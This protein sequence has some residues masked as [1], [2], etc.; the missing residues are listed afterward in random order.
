MHLQKTKRNRSVI[1]TPHGWKKLQDARRESEIWENDGERYTLET[2]SE[3]TGLG[4][5]TIAKVLAREEGVDKQT[6]ERFFSAFNLELDKD[7]YCRP[8][9]DLIAPKHLRQDWGEAVDVSAFYGRTEE[10]AQLEQWI[11]K[12]RC[13]LIALLGMGGIGKTSLSVKLAQQIQ[14]RFECVIWRSLR[15]APPLTELLANLIQFL[16]S[17]RETDLPETVGGRISRLLDY[18]R[19][20]RCLLILDN[21][22]TIL[23]SSDSLPFKFSREVRN[24]YPSGYASRAGYYREGYEEYGELLRQVGETP[25]QSC[26]VLTSRE[27][28]KELASLEGATLPIRSFQLRGLPE[29][30]GREIF[31]AKGFFSGSDA[32]WGV[33]IERYSGNP[34]ALKIVS[35]AIQELFEGK[36]YDFLAQGT[37][38]FGDIRELLDQQFNRLSDLEKES[39]YWLAINREPVLLA[40][41]RDDIVSLVSKSKLLDALESLARRGLIEKKAAL[42][43]L[44]PVV[45]EYATEKLIEEICQEIATHKIALFSSLGL[46]KAQSKY[47]VRDTQIRFILKPLSEQLL[48]MLGSQSALE[49]QLKQILSE[50]RGQASCLAGYAGGNVINLLC[51]LQTDLSGY[52]FSHLTVWQA[53]LQEVN[54]QRVNFA[55]ADQTVKLWDVSTGEVLRTLQGHSSQVWAV[56]FSPDGN[57]LA[58]GSFDQTVKLWD[59]STGEV[60]R[61]LQ[62]H[63]NFVWAIAFSPDGKLL[64]RGSE[65]Q[66]VKFW[67]VNTGEC[68]QTLQGHG[69]RIVSIAFSPQGQLLATGS[70]DR[71]V[72]LW[73]VRDGKCV[74]TL[75]GHSNWIWSVAFSPDGQTLASSSEDQSIKLW[76]VSTGECLKTLQ[77]HC[78]KVVSIAFSPDGQTLASS[79][80]DETIKLWNVNTGECLNTLRTERLYEGMNITGV[81]GLTEAIL[82]TLKALGAVE[83]QED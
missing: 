44:Q 57:T 31:K 15:N 4:V 75:Q 76:D 81:K 43:T 67:D 42:F 37:V 63:T 6:I 20:S 8:T 1:L 73:D 59:V 2:L 61:T 30:E 56:A 19:S 25:H 80:Q 47:Y 49:N 17:D 40:E 74:K 41:L 24:S 12:E 38:V 82:T 52:D 39:I 70:I 83:Y 55:H 3:R 36:I 78:S 68:L 34:L 53:Y 16:S 77:G 13:R 9:P 5:G 64:A 26:L 69:S 21:V 54:L 62:G 46:I 79:S 28:P 66:L 45:M 10:L 58:S 51:Q 71:T 33:L 35:T 7:H 14:D 72:K 18:L 32:E 29:V 27:K 65:D 23:S 11:L 48:Q 50:L 60:L 22:E